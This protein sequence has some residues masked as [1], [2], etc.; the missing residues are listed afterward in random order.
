[1][2][3]FHKLL[4]PALA[5]SLMGLISVQAQATTIAPLSTFYFSGHCS[6]C[7]GDVTARLVLQ[8]YSQGNTLNPTEFV[9]FTYDGSNL[10]SPYS[11]LPATPLFNVSGN[12]PGALPGAADFH[13]GDPSHFFGLLPSGFWQTGDPNLGDFGNSGSFSPNAPSSV[14]EPATM[15]LMGAALAAAGVARR[16]RKS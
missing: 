15:L 1:M 10:L 13:V 3:K 9:S 7:A 5:A 4:V 8:N 11:I 6:D 12:I 14:P 2:I 16:L